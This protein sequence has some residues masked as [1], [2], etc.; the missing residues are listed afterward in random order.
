MHG[1]EE[2]QAAEFDHSIM[3]EELKEHITG[4]KVTARA[5][6]RSRE[7]PEAQALTAGEPARSSS[8]QNS[9]GLLS[10]AR[11]GSDGSFDRKQDAPAGRSN[12]DAGG[13][14]ALAQ[15]EQPA[16]AGA[17][18]AGGGVKV[19][20][21]FIYNGE[22]IV[23]LRL[24]YLSAHVD[25]VVVV[26]SRTT[27]SGRAKPQ[28]FVERDARLFRPYK[29]CPLNHLLQ[30]QHPLRCYVG[31]R[32]HN[33]CHGAVAGATARLELT[34]CVL[35]KSVLQSAWDN[36][37]AQGK[38]TFLVI[39]SYPEPD[40]AWVDAQD[41]KSWVVDTTIWFRETYQRNYAAGYIRRKYAGQ[42]YVVLACD[43][44]EIPSRTVVQ[45]WRSSSSSPSTCYAMH[46][47]ST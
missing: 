42:R 31:S 29:A 25:E 46:T 5:S 4:I 21:L 8:Q 30:P 37:A 41:G 14:V 44:D 17:A 19:I 33:L 47:T 7:R 10:Q 6:V 16:A 20:D 34:C 24:Q 15:V 22:P 26:E 45:V 36:M 38:V 3:T 23:E 39:D 12:V 9:Q 28:L 2:D 43:A 32:H 18:Q 1:Q 13:Q 40:Q 35:A 27:F 11:Q